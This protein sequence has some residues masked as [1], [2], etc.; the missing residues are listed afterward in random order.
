MKYMVKSSGVYFILVGLFISP[1]LR[2]FEQNGIKITRTRQRY[3]RQTRHDN[4]CADPQGNY[5]KLM[6]GWSIFFWNFHSKMK[7]VNW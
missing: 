4:R 1:R 3:D 2:S 7:V 6:G 5:G